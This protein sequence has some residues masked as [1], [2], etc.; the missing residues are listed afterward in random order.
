MILLKAIPGLR[1]LITADTGAVGLEIFRAIY[2][3]LVLIVNGLPDANVPELVRAIKQARP[4]TGCLVLTEKFQPQDWPSDAG[5]DY[6]RPDYVL[7]SGTPFGEMSSV[8]Q[9][10]L[11]NKSAERRPE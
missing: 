3:A 7:P 2:P 6:V 8:S 1:G 9:S 4:S 10:L 11:T 5:A